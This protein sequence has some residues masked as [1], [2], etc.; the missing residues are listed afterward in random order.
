M[1][2]I[3]HTKYEQNVGNVTKRTILSGISQIF[4]PPFFFAGVK[5]HY[6]YPLPRG[7]PYGGYV[8]LSPPEAPSARQ[9]EGRSLPTK[10]T[11]ASPALPLSGNVMGSQAFY[12]DVPPAAAPATPGAPSRQRREGSAT[13]R[14][15][16]QTCRA[17]CG[18]SLSHR[19]Y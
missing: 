17:L 16:P 13:L 11:P 8:G 4:D 3:I 6:A 5:M 7:R 10:N 18:G 14:P 9:R 19:P 2:Y 1:S 12:H 15:F